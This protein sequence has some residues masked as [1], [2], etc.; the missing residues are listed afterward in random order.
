VSLDAYAVSAENRRSCG[1]EK[2]QAP[3]PPANKHH[4]V[5]NAPGTCQAPAGP[6]AKLPKPP[7]RS[8]ND[9]PEPETALE[10]IAHPMHTQAHTAHMTPAQ[11]AEAAGVSR[12]T[13]M[14]A[15][16]SHKLKAQRDNRNQWQIAPAD[17][18]AHWPHSVRK[19]QTAHPDDSAEL[20]ARLAGE[21]ARADAAERSRD[22]AEADRDRWQR[23]AQT[24]ADRPRFRWPWTR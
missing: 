2:Y 3:K 18:A 9:Q 19:V 15:I 20:R 21:T 17:L 23:M 10:Q 13:V 8:K 24:L 16:N 4:K 12:W 14:R 22:Q 5:Q 11:A 6:T 7:A 1:V